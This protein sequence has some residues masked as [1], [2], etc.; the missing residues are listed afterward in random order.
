MESPP[1]VIGQGRYQLLKTIG[2]GA[3]GR[4]YRGV[5]LATHRTV[6]IKAVQIK[7]QLRRNAN[8]IKPIAEVETLR[9]LSMFPSC[10]QFIA[11]FYEIDVAFHAPLDQIS[12]SFYI[13][14]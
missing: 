11:C 7:V 1:R 2:E 9:E 5:E 10:N 4:V 14:Y 3:F 6:A 13:Y 8:S 12:V